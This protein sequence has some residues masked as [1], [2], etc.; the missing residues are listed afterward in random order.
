MRYGVGGVVQHRDRDVQPPKRMTSGAPQGESWR[1]SATAS[2]WRN[3]PSFDGAPKNLEGR[4]VR[5]A[6]ARARPGPP[7]RSS[8]SS[9]APSGSSSNASAT[10]RSMAAWTNCR[11]AKPMPIRYSFTQL[12]GRE[13]RAG[14]CGVLCSNRCRSWGRGGPVLGREPGEVRRGQQVVAGRMIRDLARRPSSVRTSSSVTTQ[15][16]EGHD[17]ILVGDADQQVAVT[18][19]ESSGCGS[20]R[21]FS[22]Q[23]R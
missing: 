18:R 23:C 7:R 22:N 21:R 15:G 14:G 4:T 2:V 1:S 19:I 3:R 8:P 11:A 6:A 13:V 17:A 12:P 9:P 10:F 20:A 16:F 5:A